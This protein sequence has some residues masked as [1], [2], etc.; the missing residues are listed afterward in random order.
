M[1]TEHGPELEQE[2][3]AYSFLQEKIK[4]EETNPRKIVTRICR[5]GGL[6]IVFGIAACVG[7]YA[8]RP[9]AEMTFQQNPDKVELSQDEG[10]EEPVAESEDVVVKKE[11]LAIEDYHRLNA[12]LN[13]VAAE[14]KKSMVEISQVSGTESISGVIVADNGREL[15]ILTHDSELAHEANLQVEFVNGK[16]ALAT[17]KESDG[18]I[19]IAIFGVSKVEI[20]DETWDAI[21]IAELGNSS[22]LGQGRT[23]I[24]LGQPFGYSDGLGYGAVSTTEETVICADGTYGVIITDMLGVKDGNGILFDAYGKVQG[25]IAPELSDGSGAGVM[26]AY[27]ISDIT[28][29]IELMLNGKQVPYVGIIGVAVTEEMA[30]AQGIPAGLYVTEVEVDSPAMQAGIQSGDVITSVAG[31][32]IKT[33]K[34]YR[35][36]LNKQEV[37]QYLKFKGQRQGAESY[38]DIAFDVIVGVKN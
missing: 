18:N 14:A 25:I 22:A 24:A 38:V 7:F 3:E 9:W 6:G 34:G 35:V 23:L 21:K 4:E 28:G 37:G 15:L 13:Q 19:G 27:G 12:V 26:M 17:R 31:T 32:E 10:E 1:D 16:K 11:E 29:E 33:L 2:K 20:G 36:H 5:W 30:E 8:L